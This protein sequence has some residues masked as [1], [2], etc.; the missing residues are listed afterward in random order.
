M[1]LLADRTE[2]AQSGCR[3]GSAV[4]SNGVLDKFSQPALDLTLTTGK[5]APS[6]MLSRALQQA[7]GC[8]NDHE[9]Y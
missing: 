4:N 9:C 1:A 6:V 8:N 2:A 3:G 7:D 5:V